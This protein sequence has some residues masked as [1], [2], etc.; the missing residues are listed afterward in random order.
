[1][2]LPDDYPTGC[3]DEELEEEILRLKKTVS[4]SGHE[5]TASVAVVFINAGLNERL[6][7]TIEKESKDSNK[8]ALAALLVALLSVIASVVQ[9]WAS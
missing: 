9:L 2:P 1:M 3:T 6:R 7:R 4:D 5:T 8:I